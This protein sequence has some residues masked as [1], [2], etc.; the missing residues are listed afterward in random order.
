MFG[1]TG[2]NSPFYGTKYS[3]E[4]KQ[5]MS[6]AKQGKKNPMFNKKHSEVSKKKMSDKVK[7]RFECKENT[8][9]FGKKQ[10]QVECPHCGKIAGVNNI[11]RWHLD[12]CKKRLD[13]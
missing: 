5:N 3:D 2:K 12:K 6:K 11:K 13:R 1:R 9:M 7:K 8:P 4:R 10:K